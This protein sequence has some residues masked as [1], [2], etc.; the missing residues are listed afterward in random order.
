MHIR[1]QILRQSFWMWLKRRWGRNSAK[2]TL[3]QIIK[4]WYL[5]I[6]E[7]VFKGGKQRSRKWWSD[8]E[9]YWISFIKPKFKVNLWNGICLNGKIS[10]R[11]SMKRWIQIYI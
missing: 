1:N 3:I 4:K 6:D 5:Y 10:L 2:I 9:N 7:C 11:F 8:E